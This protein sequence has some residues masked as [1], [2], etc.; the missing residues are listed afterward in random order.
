MKHNFIFVVC[1]LLCLLSASQANDQKEATKAEI[2]R[3]VLSQQ[4]TDTLNSSPSPPAA[5]FTEVANNEA[6]TNQNESPAGEESS[7][8][9]EDSDKKEAL[10]EE[11]DLIGKAIDNLVEGKPTN[12]KLLHIRRHSI[13]LGNRNLIYKEGPDNG[14]DEEDENKTEE[15]I[16]KSTETGEKRHQE[17]LNKISLET[18]SKRINLK[19]KQVKAEEMNKNYEDDLRTTA[20]Q[21]HKKGREEEAKTSESGV[22]HLQ[23]AEL[24]RRAVLERAHRAESLL[25]TQTIATIQQAKSTTE[26]EVKKAE[27]H[28]Q[29]ATA[30]AHAKLHE[31]R[32]KQEVDIVH[33]KQAEEDTKK[34]AEQQLKHGH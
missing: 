30:E 19:R 17:E 33:K 11:P 21:S 12:V 24:K 16:K 3:S 22:K 15:G 23:E 6:T 1:L 28:V 4:A 9:S 8:H 10:K 5:A 18:R 25:K 34:H 14:D 7:E 26:L 31:A 27:E 13:A 2:V 29:K 32:Q 20:E